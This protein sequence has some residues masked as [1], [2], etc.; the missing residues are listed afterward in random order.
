ML[1]TQLSRFAVGIHP[2]VF[3]SLARPCLAV[4]AIP[5][6]SSAERFMLVFRF[7]R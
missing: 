3:E 5:S 1:G 4:I 7:V 6:G 2:L